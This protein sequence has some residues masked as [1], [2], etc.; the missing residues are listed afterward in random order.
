[1]P[2]IS[3]FAGIKITMNYDVHNPPHFHAQYGDFKASVLILENVID[4]GYLPNRQLKLVLAWCELHKD[5]L[6]Q[7]WEL[8]AEHENPN[9]INGLS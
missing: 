9:K 3:L 1:M 5:E 4:A 6:M 7:N 8:L 2:V